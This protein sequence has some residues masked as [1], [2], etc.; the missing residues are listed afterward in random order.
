[1]RSN[2]APKSLGKL[3]QLWCRSTG[4][5]TRRLCYPDFVVH[6]KEIMQTLP[7]SL[8]TLIVGALLA[9]SFDS[10]KTRKAFR[11]QKVEELFL[12]LSNHRN[13]VSRSLAY[14]FDVA[15]GKTAKPKDKETEETRD[16]GTMEYE[17]LVMYT[18]VYFPTLIPS[19]E[20][21][22]DVKNEWVKIVGEYHRGEHPDSDFAD[23]M[24]QLMLHFNK[25]CGNMKA[26]IVLLASDI[27]REMPFGIH[28]VLF[29]K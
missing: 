4:F 25:V 17:R 6:E 21:I 20:A 16:R 27:N 23:K 3:L 14:A 24:G 9:Y 12:A 28:K 22:E 18:N 5:T 10:F 2:G 11:L 19:L 15:T 7:L 13:S 1:M 26:N 29:R 8:I